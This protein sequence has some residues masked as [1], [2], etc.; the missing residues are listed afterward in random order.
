MALALSITV[1]AAGPAAFGGPAPTQR[2]DLV[3]SAVSGS[4]ARV[5]R[6]AVL[7]LSAKVKNQG[8]AGA[9]SSTVGWY[10]KAANGAR[11]EL[12]S[13][14]VPSLAS[15]ASVVRAKSWTVASNV[16][17][18]DYQLQA[19]ADTAGVVVEGRE[20][21]NCTQTPVTVVARPDLVVS[22]VSGS[23][24]TVE[25][26]ELLSLS[27]KVKNQGNAGARSST[28]GWYLKPAN[29]TRRDL[30][31]AGVPSLDRG[32]SVVRTRSWT[33]ASNVAAGDYQLQACADTAGVVVESREGNN[34]TQTPVTVEVPAS[35]DLDTSITSG[36]QGPVNVS[37]AQ[38]VFTSSN[39]GVSFECRLDEAL[40]AS[41]TSPANLADL[42][43]GQ[44]LFEVRALDAAAIADPSP[45]SRS[46]TVCTHL[47]TDGSD[48]LEGTEG[49]DFICG[50]GG[51]DE[52]E[53]LGGNDEID[54]GDG[55]DTV[56]YGAAVSAV[57]VNLAD[58]LATGGAGDDALANVENVTGSASGDTITGDSG[59]NSIV[60]GLGADTIDGMAGEDRLDY[61]SLAGGVAVDVDQGTSTGGSGND[62]F[63]GIEDVTGTDFD[64]TIFGDENANSLD[65]LGGIDTVNGRAGADNILGG[66]GNDFLHGGDDVDT[67]DGQAGTDTCGELADTR[68]SCELAFNG[69]PTLTIADATNSFTEG[70]APKPVDGTLTLTDDE[71]NTEGATIAIGSG[72]ESG[73]DFLSVSGGLPGGVTANYVAPTLTISGPASV[74][75]YETMLRNVKF[76]NTSQDPSVTTRTITFSVFDGEESDSGNDVA[77]AVLRIN[78]AP[79][80]DA[81]FYG[82]GQQ[83]LRMRVGTTHA[84][85]NEVEVSGNVLQG[86]VDV[87]TPEASL[88]TTAGLI[89]S[90]DCAAVCPNN[91]AMAADG[92]FTYDP[93]AGDDGTDTFTYTLEDNDTGDSDGTE[94][95]HTATVTLSRSGPRV[96]FV[97]DSAPAGGRGVSHSPLQT[98][99]PLSTGGAHDAKD[100]DGD[101]IFVYS[102]V[103]GSGLVLE[104][105]QKL[106]GE[107]NG[108][109]IGSAQFVAAGGTKPAISSATGNAVTLA[110]GTEV[111]DLALGNTPAASYSLYAASGTGAFTVADTDIVNATGGGLNLADGT[112]T[113]ALGT[114]SSS[115][116]SD[117]AL[118]ITDTDGGAVT[119]GAGVLQDA[120]NATVHLE[121]ANSSLSLGSAISDDLGRLVAMSGG[122][123]DVTFNGT[124]TDLENG[125]GDGIFITNT[126]ADV[127]FARSV[128]LSTSSTIAPAL[129]MSSSA[130]G[131]LRMVPSAGANR[132]ASSGNAALQV[133]DTTIHADGL[134]FQ[135]L[136]TTGTFDD[137]HGIWLENTGTLGKLTVTGTD[138]AG[139]GG[140]ILGR[141]EG[142]HL[143]NVNGPSLNLMKLS[144]HADYAIHGSTVRSFQMS[145]TVIDGSVNNAAGQ[146]FNGTDPATDEGAVRFDNLTGTGA[147]ITG[148]TIRQGIKNNL[149]V[150][151]TAGTLNRLTISN[152]TFS[153]TSSVGDDVVSLE[154]SGSAILNATVQNSSFQSA[155]GDHFQSL[156]Q[157]ASSG[158]I[159]FNTNTLTNNHPSSLG[160]GVRVD[161]GGS[162]DMT[163]SLNSNNITGAVATAI[164]VRKLW[165]S[166]PGDGTAVGSINNNTIGSSGVANSGSSTGSGIEASVD[167]AGRHSAQIVNN[168]IRQ[169]ARDGILATAGGTSRTLTNL[170][171]NAAFNLTVTG[172]NV[173]LPADSITASTGLLLNSGTH[174]GD[175]GTLPDQYEV[176]LQLNNN[177]MGSAGDE[178]AAS[179]RDYR[180]RQ[181]FE[182]FVRLPGYVGAQTGDTTTMTNALTSYL[183][184]RDS[185][186]GGQFSAVA[187][188]ETTEYDNINDDGFLNTAGS[189]SCSVS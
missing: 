168:A 170:A 4:P 189:G 120:V 74:A 151:N 77:M 66:D 102:G 142:I 88:T 161:A 178:L 31:S 71:T 129:G 108:L 99:A 39:G 180:F 32:A 54:G 140:Q 176:C 110:S 3:V 13:A 73:K 30:A 79:I 169:Y 19:C 41:C 185:G 165:G 61:S 58:G 96:W 175:A 100:G 171:N 104:S 70:E 63:S 86:D 141:Q 36:P 163:Y 44:H 94:D 179:G 122:S 133:T 149:S 123:G 34:C 12:A 50:L 17:A 135:R 23:P 181:R 139:S 57:T 52:I 118:R 87:D 69:A 14:G 144:G 84:D 35:G 33:V 132:A 15:G 115:N 177:A 45:A 24:T 91:V 156:I 26:G 21:N 97:D 109:L 49:E 80:A 22:A 184:G 101:R 138:S 126:S 125:T 40:W 128:L 187:S 64:D 10:L 76:E 42:T 90:S 1:C 183:T 7:S 65:G 47:G 6:G 43:P 53:G 121:N 158:D 89:T 11:R 37:V 60:G 182:T 105:N 56:I 160:A 98:L 111:Q 59:P 29:G 5:Q 188:A 155:R 112:P 78:D 137:R 67:I 173:A 167:G 114:L 117:S 16:A 72:F 2:P 82:G 157:G 152:T 127:N 159:V 8:N 75:Q 106:L 124:I 134:Q 174:A 131:S 85:T 25:R 153:N 9:R 113:V 166:A 116:A 186:L 18:G 81:D 68:L 146:P 28:V 147:T 55:V 103:Y 27:A 154:S 95:T 130:A 93:P 38:F 20:G 145:N 48:T 83:G 136:A 148:S 92:T 164:A 107:P 62:L 162:G 150:V 143:V 172:N 119:T 46:W 51:D